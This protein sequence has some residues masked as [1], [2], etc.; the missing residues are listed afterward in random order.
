MVCVGVFLDENQYD[1]YL[2]DN[3]ITEGMM[4]VVPVEHNKKAIGEVD[5]V[6]YLTRNNLPKPYR[7][8]KKII[9]I[10]NEDD[11]KQLN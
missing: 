4:V 1:Y 2:A 9:R 3:D 6:L 5:E 7:E 10:C 11:L 8:F